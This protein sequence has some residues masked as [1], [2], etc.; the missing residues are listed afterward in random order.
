MEML[1]T[2]GPG[3]KAEVPWAALQARV[4][5][6]WA[7]CGGEGDASTGPLAMLSSLESQLEDVL[8]ANAQLPS[9]AA[10]AIEQAREKERRQAGP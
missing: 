2:A 1:H 10:M 4:A 8:A 5:A 3:A 6:V 7:Q 9:G